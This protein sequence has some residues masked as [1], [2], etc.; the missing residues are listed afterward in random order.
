MFLG[1]YTVA[2]EKDNTLALPEHFEQNLSETAFLTQGFDQNLLILTDAAFQELYNSITSMNIANPLSRLLLRMLLG[3]AS[4]LERDSKGN[5][6]IPT[7][8]QEFIELETEGVLVGQGEYFEVWAPT[9]WEQ[10]IID[11]EDPVLNS[12]RFASLDLVRLNI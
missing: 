4:K 9:H 6:R 2:I 7:K 12:Q 8:L 10:Q 3:N 1:Q 5:I 11:L